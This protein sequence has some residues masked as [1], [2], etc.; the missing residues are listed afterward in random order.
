[1]E[2]MYYTNK[3]GDSCRVYNVRTNG[4]FWRDKEMR[5][6]VK[7]SITYYDY[8]VEVNNKYDLR[9]KSIIELDTFLR[10]NGF[11]FMGLDND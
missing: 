1:M 8:S 2:Y 6:Y 10:D 7:D 9:F 4:M 11:S 3:V 5:V